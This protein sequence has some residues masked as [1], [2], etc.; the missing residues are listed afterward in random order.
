MFL[1]W[2]LGTSIGVEIVRGVVSGCCCKNKHNETQRE[3]D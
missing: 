3:K 1:G 2:I